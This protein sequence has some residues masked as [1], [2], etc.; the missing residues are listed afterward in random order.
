MKTSLSITAVILA[1]GCG[2]ASPPQVAA[3]SPGGACPEAYFAV[4]QLEP[5]A[6]AT[7]DGCV[8]IYQVTSDCTV[9]LRNTID[10]VEGF[11]AWPRVRSDMVLYRILQAEPPSSGFPT[12]SQMVIASPLTT[13]TATPAWKD[14]TFGERDPEGAI[15]WDF[16]TD[17]RYGYAIGCGD[18]DQG[19]EEWT[20]S[21]IEYLRH[22]GTR[23]DTPPI[24]VFA[25]AYAAG[26]VADGVTLEG[27]DREPVCKTGD[28]RVELGT[29][30]GPIIATSPW[31]GD[32]WFVY[33]ESPG[34]RTGVASALVA[35][36]MKG[37]QEESPV[38]TWYIPGPGGLAARVATLADEGR[39]R[40]T[41]HLGGAAEPLATADGKPFELEGAIYW[42]AP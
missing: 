19:E 31:Y 10:G 28:E 17:E 24:P 29:A 12:L 25:R 11:V 40:V 15:D 5:P 20:C 34:T 22:D 27:E 14:I 8:Q 2:H 38:R 26:T 21:A 41:I 36:P 39:A 13:R 32:R 7:G 30:D 1:G 18:W 3:T 37:C 6:C 23:A 35:S 9:A 4:D 33:R 16:V 42:A